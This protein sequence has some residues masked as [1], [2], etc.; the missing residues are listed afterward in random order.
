MSSIKHDYNS[1]VERHILANQEV[2]GSILTQGVPLFCCPVLIDRSFHRNYKEKHE[3]KTWEVHKKCEISSLKQ[4]Y[5]TCF[6]FFERMFWMLATQDKHDLLH[7]ET[8]D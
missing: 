8:R 3:F 5:N 6:S 1:S 2:W 7:V 4:V